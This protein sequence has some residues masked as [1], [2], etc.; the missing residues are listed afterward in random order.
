MLHFLLLFQILSHFRRM[1]LF[2]SRISLVHAMCFYF[3]SCLHISCLS[4]PSCFFL[5][6]PFLVSNVFTVFQVFDVFSLFFDKNNNFVH[7]F[8]DK[9]VFP[10]SPF[11]FF[12]SVFVFLFTP[13]FSPLFLNRSER[14]QC[15]FSAELFLFF[16][17][18][19]WDSFSPIS[20]SLRLLPLHLCCS[21]GTYFLVPDSHGLLPPTS[22]RSL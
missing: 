22:T 17:A 1:F 5:F 6:Y 2:V 8:V 21:P 16:S 4:P 18:R 14:N 10:V 9:V 15:F 3:L 12:L 19:S 20:P 11:C 13:L 7:H